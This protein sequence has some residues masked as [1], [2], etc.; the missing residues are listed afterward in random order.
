MYEIMIVTMRVNHSSKQLWTTSEAFE[1]S[2]DQC[3]SRRSSADDD[4][5]D[6]IDSDD[7]DESSVQ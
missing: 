2:Q 7:K 3:G 5:D 1:W 4:D 6:E